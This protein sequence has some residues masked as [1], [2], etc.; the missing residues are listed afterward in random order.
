LWGGV[1]LC[2]RKRLRGGAFSTLGGKGRNGIGR[3]TKKPTCAR[4]D[5]VEEKRI[6]EEYL[7][8]LVSKEGNKETK[9]GIPKNH[10]RGRK[11]KDSKPSLEEGI[12]SERG[13]KYCGKLGA[14]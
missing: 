7:R 1:L 12:V 11:A 4:L 14:D 8:Y 6:R 9:L 13:E 10:C 5:P 3:E 2:G